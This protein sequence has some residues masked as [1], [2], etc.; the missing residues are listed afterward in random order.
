MKLEPGT[1]IDKYAITNLIGKGAM[2]EVWRAWDDERQEHVAIKVV[3]NDLIDDP[4]FRRR[5]QNEANRE[6]RHENIVPVR[7]VLDIDG[8]SCL[9]M[10]LIE[11]ISLSDLLERRRGRRLKTQEAIP[12]FIDVLHA[13]DY[14]HRKGVVHR[15]VKPSN[16]LLDENKRAYLIDF[17][18]AFALGEHRRTRTGETLGTPLYMSPEQ[19]R[20][21]KN[22]TYRSDVYSAGCLL[23]E[24]L[25]GCAPFVPDPDKGDTDFFLREAHVYKV[26]VRP[27][28]RVRSI[29]ADIDNLI[30]WALEK[31]PEKRLPGCQE[32]ARLLADR[33][34]RPAFTLGEVLAAGWRG[35]ARELGTG[36]GISWIYSLTLIIALTDPWLSAFYFALAHFPLVGGLAYI[37]IK[38]GDIGLGRNVQVANKDLLAGF[39]KFLTTL[40][41][42]WLTAF[43]LFVPMMV[44]A[45]VRVVDTAG[46]PLFPSGEY[47][48]VAAGLVAAIPIL[49]VATRLMLVFFLVIDQDLGPV[50]A[51][52]ESWRLSRGS[53]H[54]LFILMLL[55]TLLVTVGALLLHW[56]ERIALLVI[57]PVLLL[58]AGS[59]GA[60]YRRLSG[61]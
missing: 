54:K 32:F 18:I 43:I 24:M 55:A 53:T 37:G 41:A 45:L 14:A 61:T 50:K 48:A 10:T 5:F 19:I 28:R 36:V 35:L 1:R 23:Y 31:D 49:Y 8:Q 42:G 59:V 20:T 9:I 27:R 17:G 25:T 46:I 22:I 57:S 40:A 44:V 13:L 6:L 16:V 26:P 3:A 2:G 34:R 52:T 7:D 60:A 39:Q 11:G 56:K 30:M 51:I 33:D 21:P 38:L 47:V 12:I 58:L 29:P 15:D 4:E